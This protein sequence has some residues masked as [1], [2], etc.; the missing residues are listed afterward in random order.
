MFTH[1]RVYEFLDWLKTVR[2][3]CTTSC[4]Q[5]LTALKSFLCYCSSEVMSLT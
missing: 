3:N 4:N 2:G 5:R 1:E